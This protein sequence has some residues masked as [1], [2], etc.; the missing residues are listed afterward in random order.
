[1]NATTTIAAVLVVLLAAVGAAAGTGG[2]PAV[3][4]DVTGDGPTAGPT[5]VDADATYDG[6]TVTVTVA[7]DGG[8]VE[9]VT[10]AVDD[11]RATTGANGTAIVETNASGELEVELEKGGF[12]GELEYLVRNGSLT[13]VEESYEYGVEDEEVETPEPN[14]ETPDGDDADDSEEDDGDDAD[15]SEEDDGSEEDDADD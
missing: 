5:D 1:M 10:V 15:D 12:A 6:G 11:R 8:P 3:A 14:G 9:N 7:G 2:V 13:L 4:A